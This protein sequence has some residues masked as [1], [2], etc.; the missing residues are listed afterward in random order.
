MSNEEEKQTELVEVPINPIDPDQKIR[1]DENWTDENEAL[2]REW[3][4][5][6]KEASAAHN[7]AGKSNKFKHVVTG[8]P[9]ILIP[10]VFAPL[11]AALGNREGIEYVSMS[12][13]I[14]TG[15]FTGVNTFFGY[16]RKH[17]RHNDFSA[18]FSD[19]V[20]DIQY[21]LAKQRRFRSQPDQFLTRI[22][23]R[24]DNLGAQAPDL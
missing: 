17:Q 10:S 21:E 7:K 23:M 11:T 24:L 5:A 1:I 20:T 15:I 13:F 4:A 14:A 6:A 2:A 12:G 16:A 8:L 3:L 18:R 9:A 19:L 22:Q